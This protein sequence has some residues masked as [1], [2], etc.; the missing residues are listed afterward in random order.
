[1]TA[2]RRL[3]A[4]EAELDLSLQTCDRLG[5]RLAAAT[6][7][8]EAAQAD[9][10]GAV[11]R[12]A[13]LEVDLAAARAAGDHAVVRAEAVEARAAAAESWRARWAHLYP[14]HLAALS[15]LQAVGVRLADA[16]NA[17]RA[18]SAAWDA[19]DETFRSAIGHA[20]A[21]LGG[22]GPHTG[23]DD[24]EGGGEQGA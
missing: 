24:T 18:V 21:V 12:A 16:L 13:A 20:R 7:E 19:D 14:E 11:A 5:R 8:R 2:R 23:M 22:W 17:L 9:A 3:R 10:A 6:I 15:R 1:M 4:A